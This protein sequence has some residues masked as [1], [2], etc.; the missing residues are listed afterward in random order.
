MNGATSPLA[1]ALFETDQLNQNFLDDKISGKKDGS[2]MDMQEL[3]RLVKYEIPF[4]K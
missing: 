4:S 2:Q 1:Q 3:M